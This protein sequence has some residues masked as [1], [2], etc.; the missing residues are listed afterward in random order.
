MLRFIS[1]STTYRTKHGS[2]ARGMPAT[3]LPEIC[4]V[5]LKARDENVLTESQKN[6]AKKA[7]I[8]MRGLAHV[9]IIALVDEAT[10][11]QNVRARQ[12]L[13][14]ILEQ[15]IAK[16]LMP[17]TKTF[18]DAFYKDVFRLRGWNYLTLAEKGKRPSVV[19]KY[20]NNIVY[21][22]LAPGVLAEL[23]SKNPVNDKGNRKDRHHQWLT[24]DIG[25]PKLKEH[26][27]AVM[28][29]MRASTSWD[30]FMRLL[31]RAYPKLG[32]NLQLPLDDERDN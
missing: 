26:I 6:T 18:P 11:Y 4:D 21:E 1:F 5:W 3:L 25:H 30:G 10:G 8:L 29:L 9:G 31:E 12:A 22:R 16:E 15:F 17:W 27:V 2:E 24:K 7:D 32:N 28:A 20:T 23:K 19:G 14:K 13:E